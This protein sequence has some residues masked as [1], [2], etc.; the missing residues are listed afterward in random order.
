MTPQTR[1]ILQVCW[2]PLAWRKAVLEPGQRLQ[3]GRAEPA[4]LV[5]ANDAQLALLHFELEWDGQRGRIQD[6]GSPAGTLVDGERIQEAEVGHGA[7]VRAGNTD[8][9]LWFEAAT[10]PKALTSPEPVERQTRRIEAFDV[11]QAQPALWAVLDGARSERIRVLLHEC[12][13]RCQPLYEGGK[14]DALAEAAPYLV[15]LPSGSWLLRALVDEGWGHAWGIF[16]VSP[17]SFKEMR[18][19]LRKLLMV[20]VEGGVERLYMRFY[21][22]RVLRGLL[23]TFSIAQR[24]EFFGPVECVLLEDEQGRVLRELPTAYQGWT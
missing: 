1:L 14:G 2:G 13:E 10:P 17:Q 16:L 19:H 4:Q 15:S 6:L 12:V 11:L 8:F 5:V 24:Q 3:V 22:P 21:D 20:N 23:P 7:W 18:R 9:T